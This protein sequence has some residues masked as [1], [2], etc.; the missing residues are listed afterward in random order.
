VCVHVTLRNAR[1]TSFSAWVYS[2]SV[3]AYSQSK[4]PYNTRT[5]TAIYITR[6]YCTKWLW[7][8]R[9]HDEYTYQVV[10]HKHNNTLWVLSLWLQELNCATHTRLSMLGWNGF[11]IAYREKEEV[12]RAG[13]VLT[14]FPRCSSACIHICTSLQLHI[15]QSKHHRETAKL[16]RFLYAYVLKLY[17]Q[18]LARPGWFSI[19]CHLQWAYI[20]DWSATDWSGTNRI[21]PSTQTM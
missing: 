5:G 2:L 20:C 14:H 13:K 15:L 6:F 9:L 10:I 7:V 12:D 16:L 8:S 11:G 21:W 3:R 19:W 18:L 17:I 1:S 4:H